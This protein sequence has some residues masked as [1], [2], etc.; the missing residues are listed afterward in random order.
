MDRASIRVFG[1]LTAYKPD[2][3]S[4]FLCRKINQRLGPLSAAAGR[5]EKPH[6]RLLA[7]VCSRAAAV[8]ASPPGESANLDV[9]GPSRD[10]RS[11]STFHQCGSQKT[12]AGWC[13][14]VRHIRSKRPRALSAHRTIRK[15]PATDRVLRSGRISH[16]PH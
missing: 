14:A 10:A 12:S 3:L 4:E 16:L 13:D 15:P 11:A 9:K 1:D 5:R 2:D 7:R 6:A 8:P